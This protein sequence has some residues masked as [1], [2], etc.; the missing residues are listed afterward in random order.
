MWLERFLSLFSGPVFG[1]LSD[2]IGRKRG[3]DDRLL[4]CK[5]SHYLLIATKLPGLFLTVDSVFYGLV[6]WSIP[7]IMAAAIRRITVGPKKSAAAIGF[8]TFI[9]G[10]AR[11]SGPP[12]RRGAGGN[13]PDP[14]RAPFYMA[15]CVRRCVA[16]VLSGFLYGSRERP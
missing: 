3:A 15:A 11:F 5:G 7:S 14:S 16:I 12:R 6:A 4:S 1:T 10:L 8:V 9:F 13:G 2:R